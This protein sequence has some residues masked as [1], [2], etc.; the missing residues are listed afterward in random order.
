MNCVVYKYPLDFSVRTRVDLK[1]KGLKRTLDIQDQRGTPCLWALVDL[2]D[3]VVTILGVAM[4]GTGH[5][6]GVEPLGWDY[7][8]TIQAGQGVFVWHFFAREIAKIQP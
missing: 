8:A 1:I 7:V 3:P 2:D 4:S 6:M 5:S